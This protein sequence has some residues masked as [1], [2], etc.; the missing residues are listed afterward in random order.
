MADRAAE[1]TGR[2]RDA[3]RPREIPKPGWRDVLIRTWNEMGRD[4]VSMIAAGVG[5][6]GLLALFPAI[7]AIISLWGLVFDPAAIE[8]QIEQASGALPEQA[9]AIVEEQARSV[10]AGAGGVGLAAIGG[11]LLTL[12]SATKG[13]KS[14]IEG[15]NIIYDEE[16]SRGFV[17][18][19]LVAFGLTLVL[20][21]MMLAALGLIVVLPAL[22]G[23]VGL[24][25]TAETL[26]AL[27]RVPLLALVAVLGLAILYRFAPSRAS[28]RWRWISWGAVIATL[29]WVI[30]SIAFSVYVRNFGSYNET[31]GS[32]G[33]MIVLL[34]WF[35][36]SAYIVLMGAEL[37]SEIEHQ[38]E[39]DSTT[40]AWKPM[41]ERGARAADT[42]GR[43][44]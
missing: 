39:R 22:L 12:Y 43:A 33:A 27:L 7:A 3:E 4:H 19:N 29:L 32:I 11:L 42:V 16:E 13:V 44:H 10:A 15:L 20:I 28:P 25:G 17:R 41:G 40:G 26:I 21:V 24:G 1:E 30:G 35:W 6:Y 23:V 9:A 34:M 37:N 14:L 31:Y 5:F 8:S 38:T 2:G 36:L 18:V